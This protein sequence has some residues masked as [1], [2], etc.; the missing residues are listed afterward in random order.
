[1]DCSEI[2]GF[3]ADCI[4]DGAVAA[5]GRA[6][7]AQTLVARLETALIF[8]K[9]HGP[10]FATSAP[11]S[12]DVPFNLLIQKENK[13]FF[14]GVRLHAVVHTMQAAALRRRKFSQFAVRP[15]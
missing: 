5:S 10:L 9:Y 3:R 15:T 14:S 1:M 7:I 12:G 11:K 6:A 2:A 8:S 4:R 13:D